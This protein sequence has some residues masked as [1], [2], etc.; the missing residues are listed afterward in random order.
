MKNI[1]KK[2]V[3][4]EIIQRINNLTNNSNPQWGKMNVAQMLAHLNVQ[5]EIIYENDKFP[6]PNFIARF[7]LKNVVKK[8]VT[9]PKPFSKNGRTAPYFIISSQKDFDKEKE[10]L[11]NYMKRIQVD[12][13]EVLLPRDTKSFGK[14][15]AEEW[16]TLFY[17]H[18]DHH[19]NQF[20][21]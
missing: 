15:T 18:L 7:F 2:E 1:F 9:G 20:A 12:G 10:R 13:V 8:A 3:S 4:Q 6:K 11:I 17:K 21:V 16:N 5:Y 14:L 19:L